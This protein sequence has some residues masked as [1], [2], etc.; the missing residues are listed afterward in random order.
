MGINVLYFKVGEPPEVVELPEGDHLKEMQKLVGGYVEVT[1]GPTA[2]SS[3]WCNEEGLLEE[4]PLQKRFFGVPPIAGNFF[5]TSSRVGPDGETIGLDD[6]HIQKIKNM[7][8]D[9]EEN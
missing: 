7:A 1:A 6:L 9:Y 5:I 3:L 8:A 4:L 2:G